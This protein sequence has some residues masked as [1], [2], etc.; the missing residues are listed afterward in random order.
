MNVVVANW[1][2]LRT[3]IMNPHLLITDKYQTM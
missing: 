1:L 3:T 2:H